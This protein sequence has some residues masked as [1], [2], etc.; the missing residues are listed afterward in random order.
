M[1]PISLCLIQMGDK[2]LE[3]VRAFPDVI[4]NEIL[5][6]IVIKSM[7][8]GAKEGDFTSSIIA[9]NNAFSGYV[10]CIPR[11]NDRNNIAS[12]VAI[13]E[14]IKYDVNN[15]RNLFSLIITEMKKYEVISTDIL[16]QILPTL[17][18]SFESETIKIKISS[19]VTIEINNKADDEL[20]AKPLEKSVNSFEKDMWK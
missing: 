12:L 9:G 5:N 16:T 13:Y 11:S 14:N 15:V 19:V 18:K 6:E 17:Y 2:G 1:K 4:P 10:F 20:P 7:P 3:C 8:M